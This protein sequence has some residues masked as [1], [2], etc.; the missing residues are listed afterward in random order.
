MIYRIIA[1]VTLVHLGVAF[2]CNWAAHQFLPSGAPGLSRWIY[3]FLVIDAV[4]LYGMLERRAPIF[5]RIWYQGPASSAVVALT[6][7][8]GPTDPCTLR[9]L[10]ILKR[11]D[12]KATFFMLGQNAERHPD[13]VRRVAAEGHEIGNHSFDH[14]VLPLKGP[15]YIRSTI[16]RTSDAIKRICGVRPALF[17]APHGWRNPFVDR[18]AREEGCEPVAWTLGVYDTDHP[19]AETIRDRTVAGLV[20]GCVVLLHD[21]RGIEPDADATQL[22]EALP[23]I[24]EGAR[25]RGFTFATVGQL[26]AG[27]PGS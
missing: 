19:G 8:D 10:D 7:D 23:G 15:A 1:L 24:I 5:G 18:V 27:A 2:G 11:Y 14:V 13:V 22:V 6:F 16:R 4:V 26:R 21:G 3:L 12:V 25:R 9:I 20:N 17:R